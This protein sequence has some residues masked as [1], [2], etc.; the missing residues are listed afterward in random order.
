[1]GIYNIKNTDL[2]IQSDGDVF[3]LPCPEG[4]QLV[5]RLAAD[6]FAFA[7]TSGLVADQQDINKLIVQYLDEPLRG[8]GEAFDCDSHYDIDGYWVTPQVIDGLAAITKRDIHAMLRKQA[9]IPVV[10]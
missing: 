5:V 2:H 8:W 10:P 3:V 6:G 4:K 1:M 9:S 7:E